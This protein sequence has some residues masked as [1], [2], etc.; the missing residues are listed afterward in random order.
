MRPKKF[1]RKRKSLTKNQKSLSNETL[2]NNSN[3]LLETHKSFDGEPTNFEVKT[4]KLIKNQ[5]TSI[6]KN[7]SIE[8]RKNLQIKNY[9]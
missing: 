1:E 7:T 2:L 3:S 8:N 5:K 9:F 6:K 4:K